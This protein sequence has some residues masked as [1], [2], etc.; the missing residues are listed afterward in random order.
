[1][2]NQFHEQ[3][4]GCEES[5][6]QMLNQTKKMSCQKLEDHAAQFGALA[7]KAQQLAHH[8]EKRVIVNNNNDNDD[9]DDNDNKN[10][11]TN[12]TNTNT[13][14]TN[15][16]AYFHGESLKHQYGSFTVPKM[17]DNFE[18]NSEDPVLKLFGDQITNL[19]SAVDSA[20]EQIEHSLENGFIV[21]PCAKY[22][23][24]EVLTTKTPEL[25][26]NVQMSNNPPF[27]VTA[28]E[29][30][31][32]LKVKLRNDKDQPIDVD[33]D[34]TQL[35]ISTIKDGVATMVETNFK[36]DDVEHGGY[37]VTGRLLTDLGDLPM[38]LRMMSIASK[39]KS[40]SP[41]SSSS[42]SAFI[43][44]SGLVSTANVNPI[45]LVLNLKNTIRAFPTWMETTD[46][47]NGFRAIPGT[48]L[49]LAVSK[50]NTRLANM[51]EYVMPYG[52]RW[53]S[54]E[55]AC[56]EARNTTQP[57]SMFY[58]DHEGWSGYTWNGVERHVFDFSDS[59]QTRKC[60]SAGNLVLDGNNNASLYSYDYGDDFAGLVCIA[61]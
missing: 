38:Q 24:I 59:A 41:S 56:A 7:R 33:L 36:K 23:T 34:V 3:L 43:T 30:T 45:E 61:E 49:R 14:R 10:T 58:C 5:T 52:H 55:E 25:N 6:I 18:F 57:Q 51:K 13:D 31:F 53:A 12:N 11:T 15:T 17:P 20:S 44:F 35:E 50:S 19:Q 21:Q 1:L 46:N 42:V 4:V 60:F 32:E 28:D 9:N 47:A 48:R 39:S 29:L 22:T 40:T 8:I 27:V 54:Q 26:P 37:L 16:L 2:S